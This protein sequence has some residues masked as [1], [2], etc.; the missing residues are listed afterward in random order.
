M[1]VKSKPID[2]LN[3]IEISFFPIGATKVIQGV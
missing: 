1:E 3:V 2:A